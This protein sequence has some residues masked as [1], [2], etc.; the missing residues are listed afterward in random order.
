MTIKTLRMILNEAE[1]LYR[2]AGDQKSVACLHEFGALLAPHDSKT[3]DAFVKLASKPNGQ[4][5]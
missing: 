5:A 3:V 1:A 2:A 4:E